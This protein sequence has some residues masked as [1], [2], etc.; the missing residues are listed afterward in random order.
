LLQHVGRDTD[1]LRIAGN[2]AEGD[3]EGELSVRRVAFFDELA[4]L[5]EGALLFPVEIPWA[6]DVPTFPNA[7]CETESSEYD[8][9]F[10]P[11]RPAA[12]GVAR[13]KKLH[14]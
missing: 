8:D 10:Y 2:G 12:F 3:V 11:P 7:K 1:D 14:A 6:R 13:L 4:S 9:E 5:G